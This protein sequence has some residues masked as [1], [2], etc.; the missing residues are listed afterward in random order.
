MK[1]KA[2]STKRSASLMCPPG[3]GRY[4][5]ISPRAIYKDRSASTGGVRDGVLTIPRILGTHHDAVANRADGDVTEQETNRPALLQ[6]RCRTQEQTSTDDTCVMAY[7]G[8]ISGHSAPVRYSPPILKSG[9]T[10]DQLPMTQKT[11]GGTYLIIA[12]C[13]FLS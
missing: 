9:K 10:C 13:L 12:M 11:S 1:E 6:R 5:I 4:A 8:H 3:R 7:V 2:G